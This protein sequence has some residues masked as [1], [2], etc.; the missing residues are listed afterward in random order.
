MSSDIW[1][2]SMCRICGTSRRTLMRTELKNGVVE[3]VKKEI[4]QGLMK[5]CYYNHHGDTF[6]YF[7]LTAWPE[8]VH[9][10][11]VLNEQIIHEPTTRH[12]FYLFIVT[13]KVVDHQQDKLIPVITNVTNA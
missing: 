13:V 2:R 9:L 8:V 12:P 1:L 5:R 3:E 10:S 11:Y 7:P 6:L 4:L